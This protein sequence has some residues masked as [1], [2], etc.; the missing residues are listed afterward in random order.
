MI[1]KLGHVLYLGRRKNCGTSFNAREQRTA[2]KGKLY[3]KR[4][5]V[6]GS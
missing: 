4:E 2:R 6:I 5:Y 3:W 1:W